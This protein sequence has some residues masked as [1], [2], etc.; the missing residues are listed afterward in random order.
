MRNKWGFKSE[1]LRVV[2]TIDNSPILLNYRTKRDDVIKLLQ[3]GYSFVFD[4]IL[5]TAKRVR[6]NS[7]D[8]IVPEAPKKTKEK[9]DRSKYAKEYYKRN[10]EALL[11]KQTEYGKR[12]QEKLNRQAR[13]RYRLNHPKE[14]Q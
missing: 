11:K 9:I 8:E 3:N 5:E 6:E 13:E 2:I 7:N 10:R 14:R 12:N 4:D 1:Y